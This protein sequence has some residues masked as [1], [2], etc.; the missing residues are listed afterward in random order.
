MKFPL[1][2]VLVQDRH[3]NFTGK[4]NTTYYCRWWLRLKQKNVELWSLRNFERTKSLD[5]KPFM[6]GTNA[7]HWRRRRKIDMAYQLPKH[8]LARWTLPSLLFHALWYPPMTHNH[9]CL[10]EDVFSLRS[11]RN[12]NE[13][14]DKYFQRPFLACVSYEETSLFCREIGVGSSCPSLYRL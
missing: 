6:V 13:P 3:V 1:T 7:Q 14:I 8:L 2:I 4:R 11:V 10:R 12:V 9:S 5:C